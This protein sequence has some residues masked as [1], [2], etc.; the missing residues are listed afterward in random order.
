[1]VEN[2]LN[3]RAM[4]RPEAVVEPVTQIFDQELILADAK[5]KITVDSDTIT[6][7]VERNAQGESTTRNPGPWDLGVEDFPE[8]TIDENDRESL[9]LSGLAAKLRMSAKRL[10][11]QNEQNALDMAEAIQRMIR[12]F[13]EQL[14]SDAFDAHTNT[15]ETSDGGEFDSNFS[16]GTGGLA[17]NG[18]HLVYTPDTGEEWDAGGDALSQLREIVTVFRTQGRI[19]SD[20]GDVRVSNNLRAYTDGLTFGELHDQLRVQ[21]L[22]PQPN[23]IPNSIRVPSIYNI[24]IIQAD[25]AIQ[26]DGDMLIVDEGSNPVVGYYHVYDRL[27]DVGFTNV[28]VEGFPMQQRTVDEDNGDAVVSMASG[29]VFA[30]R[31][32]RYQMLAHGLLQ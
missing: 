12:G 5:T 25:F 15:R 10:E 20:G 26:N 16:A 11:F 18:G 19:N 30:N 23:N 24:D 21:G 2:E 13:A 4:L 8:V 9:S 27:E 7:W 32:P 14:E 28:N 6:Y 29:S 22:D 1:M 31:K 17:S 3:P